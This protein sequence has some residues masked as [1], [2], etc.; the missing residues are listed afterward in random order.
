MVIS[1]HLDGGIRYMKWGDTMD[2]QERDLP[3]CTVPV[4]ETWEHQKLPHDSQTQDQ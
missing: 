3:D 2:T 4:F 1:V